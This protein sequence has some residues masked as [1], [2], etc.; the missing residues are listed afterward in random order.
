MRA[1]VTGGAGFLGSRVV[2]K[3]RERGV[4]PYVP[5]IGV[6]VLVALLLH[7]NRAAFLTLGPLS[8][9]CLAGLT[10][11]RIPDWHDP[12][13]LWSDCVRKNPR[14]AIGHYSLAGCAI[15]EHDWTT[16]ESQLRTSIE[17]KPDFAEARR[18]LAHALEM[19]NAPAGR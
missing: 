15:D 9:I 7:R 11:A 6:F 14:S 16:A 10:L 19:K 18:N 2:E 1:V 13:T 17:L 4:E 12:R 8:A 3:L 5:L